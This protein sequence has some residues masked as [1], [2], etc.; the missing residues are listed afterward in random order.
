MGPQVWTP[1]FH[2]EQVMACGIFRMLNLVFFQAPKNT[3][4]S[5]RMPCHRMAFEHEAPQT[6]AIDSSSLNNGHFGVRSG[7][8][9]R[10]Q[11]PPSKRSCS[12][13]GVPV[14]SLTLGRSFS[15]FCSFHW[16]LVPKVRSSKLDSGRAP[17]CWFG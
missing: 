3:K 4:H 8:R 14:V 10:G 6:M 1:I 7:R 9:F 12:I 5:P 17:P 15:L 2:P 16:G 11:F 13:N